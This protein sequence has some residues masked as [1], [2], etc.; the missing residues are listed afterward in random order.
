MNEPHV[1]IRLSLP[2]RL[3]DALRVVH[4]RNQAV[5]R[6]ASESISTLVE[7]AIEA[8]LAEGAGPFDDAP[9]LVPAAKPRPPANRAHM[10]ALRAEGMTL[11]AIVAATGATLTTVYQAVRGVR[12]DLEMRP[13]LTG[14]Q[15]A[16]VHVLYAQGLSLKAIAAQMSCSVDTVRRIVRRGR[17]AVASAGPSD[18]GA[19]H[20]AG[21]SPGP[22]IQPDLEV[23]AERRAFPCSSRTPRHPRDPRKQGP[24]TRCPD[25]RP[26]F[27]TTEDDTP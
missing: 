11:P 18:A 23:A 6:D 16:H 5:E 24:P 27:R 17:G 10:R 3:V 15:R 26:T 2:R 4:A 13:R 12:P 19:G 22:T 9:E 21:H 25:S 7:S 20:S 8:W 1:R 14:E